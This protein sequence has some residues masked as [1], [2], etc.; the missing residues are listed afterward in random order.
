MQLI[1][2][3]GNTFLFQKHWYTFTCKK[4]SC[5]AEGYKEISK[6]QKINKCHF[7][8]GNKYINVFNIK[9]FNITQKE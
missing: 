6:S 4:N 8:D 9:I 7:V 2:E 3:T 1:T 5:S